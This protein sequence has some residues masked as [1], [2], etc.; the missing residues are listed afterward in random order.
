MANTTTTETVAH[1]TLPCTSPNKPSTTRTAAA[2]APP[3][4]PAVRRASARRLAL[5]SDTR[6]RACSCSVLHCL[7]TATS[8]ASRLVSSSAASARA[9]S[10]LPNKTSPPSLLREQRMTRICSSYPILDSVCIPARSSHLMIQCPT[11]CCTPERD[12]RRWRVDP[13][14]V[15]LPTARHAAFASTGAASRIVLATSGMSLFAI[16]MLANC[17]AGPRTSG[18]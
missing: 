1:I 17:W 13:Q 7:K 4:Y 16:T 9:R 10:S 6:F 18:P 3:A 14:P 2:A 12:T 8:R 5:R 15:S 11:P